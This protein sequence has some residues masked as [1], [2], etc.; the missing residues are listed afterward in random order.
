MSPSEHVNKGTSLLVVV[1]VATLVGMVAA[2][3]TAY[4]SQHV[5]HTRIELTTPYQAVQLSNGAAYF[6]RIKGLGTPYPVLEELYFIQ[7]TQNPET[8]QVNNILLRRGGEW[9][10]PDRMIVNANS[11]VSVEPVNPNSRVA[12]L[13]SEE[14]AKQAET[15]RP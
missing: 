2:G 13:I 15:P 1:I 4:F 7:R 3:V 11:I 6:C 14:K 12:Q 10:Q 9:W 5:F 8:K